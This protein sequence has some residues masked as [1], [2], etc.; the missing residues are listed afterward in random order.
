MLGL[1]LRARALFWI[2]EEGIAEG[3]GIGV[4]KGLLVSLTLEDGV[5]E[6]AELVPRRIVLL[7]LPL[8]ESVTEPE[9]LREVNLG[10]SLLLL[11]VPVTDKVE[12]WLGRAD[13]ETL[14]T[15]DGVAEPVGLVLRGRDLDRLLLL[16]TEGTE[17]PEVLSVMEI[18][19]EALQLPLKGVV[20]PVG[21]TLGDEDGE[22]EVESLKLPLK[23]VV[24]ESVGLTLGDEDGEIEAE[25]L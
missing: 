7:T 13:V 22:I 1:K 21:L 2:P 9:G 20:E 16:L 25:A 23:E 14:L 12:V 4:R 24:V 15:D 18:E 5:P 10:Q 3:V 8:A 11:E 19:A 17:V 6:A